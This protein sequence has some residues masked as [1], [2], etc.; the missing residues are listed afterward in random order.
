MVMQ[1]GMAAATTM[2]VPREEGGGMVARGESEVPREISA[3]DY[4][5]IL[6]RYSFT[7]GQRKKIPLANSVTCMTLHF[8]DK[9]LRSNLNFYSS[10]CAESLADRPE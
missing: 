4:G 8:V 6:V 2:P 3:C 9:T 1:A 5:V 7:L 10:S